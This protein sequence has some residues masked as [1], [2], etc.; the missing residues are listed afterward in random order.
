MFLSQFLAP[1]KWVKG[2]LTF[3]S[4]KC[5]PLVGLT[6]SIRYVLEDPKGHPSPLVWSQGAKFFL[7]IGKKY[8]LYVSG[9]HE[10]GVCEGFPPWNSPHFESQSSK[11]HS[12]L[13]YVVGHKCGVVACSHFGC[14]PTLMV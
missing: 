4:L 7:I 9:P 1:L 6:I 5:R 2:T 11:L 10:V 8:S 13:G 12:M 3:T 14:G